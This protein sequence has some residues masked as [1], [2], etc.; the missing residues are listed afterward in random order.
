MITDGKLTQLLESF[1]R[2][3]RPDDLEEAY[4]LSSG[5]LAPL[6][7]LRAKAALGG[8]SRAKKVRVI[9]PGRAAVEAG[10]KSLASQLRLPRQER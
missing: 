5:T 3:A 9:P 7:R 1:L 8:A 4:G 6:W 10:R 2:G